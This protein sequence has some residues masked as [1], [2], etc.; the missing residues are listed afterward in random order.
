M[1][2][3]IQSKILLVAFFLM[4][5]TKSYTMD[6]VDLGLGFRMASSQNNARTSNY[7]FAASDVRSQ[8][9][10]SFGGTAQI[11]MGPKFDFALDIIASRTSL[12]VFSNQYTVD[13]FELSFWSIDFPAL[14]YFSPIPNFF[15]G[16][17]GYASFGLGSI[18]RLGS[19]SNRGSFTSP[20]ASNDKISYRDAG[21]KSTSFG[22]AIS[23]GASTPFQGSS[24][25]ELYVESR[26]YWGFSNRQISP[27]EQLRTYLWDIGVGLIFDVL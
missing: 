1:K 22:G 9:G 2:F 5:A 26:L 7:F 17:G 16:I 18:G 3:K 10:Y 20:V 24:K 15:I 23:I 4:S 12:F 25:A 14:V 13:A 6:G 27:T 8:A 21:W 11:K 19:Y